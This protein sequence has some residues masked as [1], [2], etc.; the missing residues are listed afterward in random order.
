M[1]TFRFH[2]AS[3]AGMAAAVGVWADEVNAARSRRWG[4]PRWG[5]PR[6]PPRTRDVGNPHR[7]RPPN[8][9]LRAVPTSASTP[10]RAPV[11]SSWVHTPSTETV[12]GTGEETI[13]R[14]TGTVTD[15]EPSAQ[16]GGLLTN[17]TATGRK[18]DLGRAI[19]GSTLWAAET[20]TERIN[21]IRSELE[22]K[23]YDLQGDGALWYPRPTPIQTCQSVRPTP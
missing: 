21:R 17:V 6:Y 15:L 10:G 16:G 11:T 12:E 5:P 20:E 7:H 19:I 9:D 22:V 8:H 1:F 4:V 3:R 18:S 2:G 23:G 14:F 13:V